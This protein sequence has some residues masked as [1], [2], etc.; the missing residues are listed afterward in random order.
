MTF[1]YLHFFTPFPLI[2]CDSVLRFY[3]DYLFIFLIGVRFRIDDN[4][5][6]YPYFPPR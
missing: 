2:F 1:N 5:F 6:P 4:L 3:F